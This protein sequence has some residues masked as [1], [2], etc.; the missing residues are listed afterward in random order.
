MA[1][2]K[3]Q[4]GLIVCHTVMGNQLGISFQSRKCAHDL[5]IAHAEYPYLCVLSVMSVI[6]K[7]VAFNLICPTSNGIPELKVGNND[8]HV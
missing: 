1:L 6:T 7:R 5:L 8:R 4:V 2:V 3:P